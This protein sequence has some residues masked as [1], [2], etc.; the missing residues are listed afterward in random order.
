[1]SR[2]NSNYRRGQLFSGGE[3]TQRREPN[4]ISSA[5]LPPPEGRD[6][7]HLQYPPPP[8]QEGWKRSLQERGG[9]GA[10]VHPWNPQGAAEAETPSRCRIPQDGGRFDW[11]KPFSVSAI[12]EW[13]SSLPGG[14]VYGRALVWSWNTELGISASKKR[15]LYSSWKEN[16]LGLLLHDYYYY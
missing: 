9:N 3:T 1:M 6:R 8:P 10:M 14:A 12:S 4:T 13:K 7:S 16:A 2:A 11:A 15:T 5:P